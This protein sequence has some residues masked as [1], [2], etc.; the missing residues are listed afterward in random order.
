M[1]NA[2]LPEIATRE[3]MGRISGFGWALGYVGST[4]SLL[5]NLA[6]I[7]K[8]EWFSPF[9]R[10]LSARS[11]FNDRGGVLVGAVRNPH[12]SLAQRACRAPGTSHREA[13]TYSMGF[14]RL[15]PHL[16]KR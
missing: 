3:K 12:L 5:L 4:L 10:K 2:F 9:H 1:Y 15:L 8:P 6:I 11:H 14:Q 13:A 16:S 7:G